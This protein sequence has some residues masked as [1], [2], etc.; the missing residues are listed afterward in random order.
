M[1]DTVDN[2]S[3]GRCADGA[4]SDTG[5]PHWYPEVASRPGFTE[6]L[7]PRKKHNFVTGV[8]MD[9]ADL[10]EV[11]HVFRKDKQQVCY[12]ACPRCKLRIWANPE[13]GSLTTQAGQHEMLAVVQFGERMCGHDGIVH[14]GAT[15]TVFDDLFG[16][17]F[18]YAEDK[19]FTAALNTNYRKPIPIH[20]PVV[21][22]L[23]VDK[24][25]GRKLHASATASSG[26]G[27]DVYATSD[28][29]YIL[30]RKDA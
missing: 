4:R 2:S 20:T 6:V 27:G 14:G 7:L 24:R 13:T 15:A 19:C 29:L 9:C 18:E 22:H 17:L 23:V 16:W 10:F 30:A 28:T 11:Y 1:T 5:L 21:F 3:C 26:P 25:E 12:L 8:L